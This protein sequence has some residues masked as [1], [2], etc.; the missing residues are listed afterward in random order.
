[1]DDNNLLEFLENLPISNEDKKHLN[2]LICT[3]SEVQSEIISDRL[4]EIIFTNKDN[5]NYKKAQ[6][7]T[8]KWIQNQSIELMNCLNNMMKINNN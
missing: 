6:D 4:L 8:K 5:D 7:I 3:I 1:M 2:L